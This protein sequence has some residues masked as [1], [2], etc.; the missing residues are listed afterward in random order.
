MFRRRFNSSNNVL[1]TT[2]NN[3]RSR[4]TSAAPLIITDAQQTSFNV[5]ASYTPRMIVARL[6]SSPKQTDSGVATTS[7]E[8]PVPGSTP[9]SALSSPTNQ[10]PTGKGSCDDLL[11]KEIAEQQ[12]QQNEDIGNGTKKHLTFAEV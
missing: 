10:S 11:T 4:T 8:T 9:D 3:T 1:D 5:T 2:I 7:S 6:P 12:K